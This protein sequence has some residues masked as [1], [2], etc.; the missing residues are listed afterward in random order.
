MR[1]RIAFHRCE[2]CWDRGFSATGIGDL[3][4]AAAPDPTGSLSRIV[5]TDEGIPYNPLDREDPDI[6]LS[7]EERSIGGLG[8]FMARK[9][10]DSLEYTCE[11][12]KNC[13]TVEKNFETELSPVETIIYRYPQLILTPGEGMSGSEAYLDIT[14]R[15]KLPEELPNPFR[16]SPKDYLRIK[17]HL[18]VI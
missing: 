5:I 12:G 8:I 15:G 11:D 9:F 14:R 16:G 6:T 3:D 7:T 2:P 1:Q 10:L 17:K 4:G 13:L 18:R